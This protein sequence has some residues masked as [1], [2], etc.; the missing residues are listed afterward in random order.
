MATTTMIAD[1]SM[2]NRIPGS[3]VQVVAP[4]HCRATE[5]SLLRDATIVGFF[6]WVLIWTRSGEVSVTH[7]G[8]LAA[9][10]T[11]VAGGL[12]GGVKD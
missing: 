6:A 3:F 12:A 7:L 10:A 2:L 11:S 1:T 4:G 9:I 8:F 5:R